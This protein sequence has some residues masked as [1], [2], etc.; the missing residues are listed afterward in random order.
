[1]VATSFNAFVDYFP[2]AGLNCKCD[3][4]NEFEFAYCRVARSK[5]L[6]ENN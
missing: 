3:L 5:L 2:K 4:V 1:M 6:V